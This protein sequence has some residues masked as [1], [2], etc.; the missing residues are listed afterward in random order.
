[1][2]VLVLGASGMLGHA[3]AQTFARRPELEVIAAARRP[4]SLESVRDNRLI[5]G[6]D[7]LDDAAL[8]RLLEQVRP[9]TVLNAVGLIKQL[10]AADDPD[11]ALPTNAR[12]PHRLADQCEHAGARLVHVSTDCVFSGARGSY[13]EADAP[14]A[15]D[16]YGRSKLEGEVADRAHA[17]TLRTSLVGRERGTRNG[18]IEWFLHAGS[19]VQG[20]RNFVFSGLTTI[21]F[22]EA[23]ADHVLPRPE[24]SGVWHIGGPPIDKCAL[25]RLT[26]EAYGLETEIEPVDEPRIDRSLDSGRF[27]AATGFEPPSWPEMIAAMRERQG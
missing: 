10:K 12:L 23:L 6:V 11:Q 8:A 24:L 22:A 27:N 7:A 25:L 16:V 19:R 13:G 14:D 15:T 21:A 9:D 1:M 2:R 3:A 18:L 20:Y 17:I 26:A 4:L 5:T